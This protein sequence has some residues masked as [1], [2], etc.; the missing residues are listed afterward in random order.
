[1]GTV[2]LM[3]ASTP[4]VCLRFILS[5]FKVERNK[6]W[7]IFQHNFSLHRISIIFTTLSSMQ[8]DEIH[9]VVRCQWTTH[10]CFLSN[11]PNN[12]SLLRSLLVWAAA[13][14]DY[15]SSKFHLIKLTK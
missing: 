4:F 3:E 5:K 7:Q 9:P 2:Y 10:A 14:Y 12:K 11:F 6:F 8:T 13:E 1:M 15:V